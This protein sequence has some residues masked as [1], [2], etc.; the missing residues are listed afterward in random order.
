[1]EKLEVIEMESIK[2][3][4]QTQKKLELESLKL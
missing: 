3:L 2:K 1:M 4:Q